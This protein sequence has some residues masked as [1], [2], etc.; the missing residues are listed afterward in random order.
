MESIEVT[1][2]SFVL[3]SADQTVLASNASYRSLYGD[4]FE[5]T[6]GPITYADLARYILRRTLPPAE[7]ESEVAARVRQHTVDASSSF[8]RHY[9]DGRWLSITNR[10][11]AGGQV[12]GFAVDITSLRRRELAIKAMIGDFEQGTA[13]LATTLTASSRRLEG[14]ARTMAEAADDSNQRAAAVA[15]AAQTTSDSVQTVA[16]AAEQLAGSIV[17]ITREVTR[18]AGQSAQGVVVAR[19]TNAIVHA[20][21]SGAENIGLVIGLI[22]QIAGQTKLL[23]LN[24]SIEAARAGVAGQGFAVVAAEV[25]ALAQQTARATG[26]I[27]GQLVEIQQATGQAAVAVGDIS[28]IMEEV[29][30]SAASVAA[31]IAEQGRATAA[32]TRTI[33]QTSASTDFVSATVS[34]VSK[35]ANDTRVAAADVLDSVSGLAARARDL[36]GKVSH[37]LAGVRAA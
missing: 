23:A 30:S 14:T 15:A 2:A 22:S 7:L 26:E 20:L 37:F 11:L 5:T 12:A 35:S 9:P 21:A 32:I 25:K 13:E 28:A 17:S 29:S 33:H 27:H 31:A 36:T 18:S 10:K 3:F 6:T 1:P 4:L 24:A 19:R 16:S 34:D 8:E